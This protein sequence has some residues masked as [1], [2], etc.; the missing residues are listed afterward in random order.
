MIGPRGANHVGS[1]LVGVALLVAWVPLLMFPGWTAYTLS[2][3][4]STLLGLAG[5]WLV[6]RS[7]RERETSRAIV[8][9][10]RTITLLIIAAL[11]WDLR[12]VL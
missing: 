12:G 11:V 3:V 1:A 5:G 9:I 4:L 2:V 10:A 8:L 7:G 6:G